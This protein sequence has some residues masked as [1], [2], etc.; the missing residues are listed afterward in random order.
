MN[1]F[2]AM[3]ISK[4]ICN[5]CNIFCSPE[6]SKALSRNNFSLDLLSYQIT[7]NINF[8]PNRKPGGYNDDNDG[9]GKDNP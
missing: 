7:A 2:L 8:P 4:S 5:L 6:I 3:T 9:G 1:Y